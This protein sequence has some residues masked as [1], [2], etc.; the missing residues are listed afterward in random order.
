[1]TLKPLCTW[2]RSHLMNSRLSHPGMSRFQ[3]KCCRITGPCFVERCFF[4]LQVVWLLWQSWNPWAGGVGRI[5]QGMASALQ[6]CLAL[7]GFA[8]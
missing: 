2:H 5:P 6:H 3:S 8:L 7:L 1:M 4:L